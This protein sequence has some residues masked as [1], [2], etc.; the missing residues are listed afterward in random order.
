VYD[1][2]EKAVGVIADPKF[3]IVESSAFNELLDAILD[4]KPRKASSEL[5]RLIRKSY[6]PP[7]EP[8]VYSEARRNAL[9]QLNQWTDIQLRFQQYLSADQFVA[10][11]DVIETLREVFSRS[12]EVER[13]FSRLDNT[14][15]NISSSSMAPQ[16]ADQLLRLA[17]ASVELLR[18]STVSTAHTD[19]VS[20]TPSP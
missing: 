12:A 4:S 14:S 6:Y 10:M 7:L 18:L 2:I 3:E 13:L 17:E 1:T 20:V 5:T 8:N 16:L 9:H 11:T 19:D 15:Q